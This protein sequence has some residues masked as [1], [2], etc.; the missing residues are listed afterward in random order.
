VV[1]SI[2]TRILANSVWIVRD[3]LRPKTERPVTATAGVA[4]SSPAA[5]STLPAGGI[6]GNVDA[7]RGVPRNRFRRMLLPVWIL[8]VLDVS[9]AVIYA[10]RVAPPWVWA[11]IIFL[12]VW[13]VIGAIVLIFETIKSPS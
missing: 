9:A 3:H 13:F 7:K 1:Q 5:D 4:P 12:A 11:W 2:D 8:G 6:S 10:E